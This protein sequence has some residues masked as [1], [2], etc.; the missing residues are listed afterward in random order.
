M[1]TKL[2]HLIFPCLEL[3]L[4][5]NAAGKKHN[6]Q[7]IRVSCLPF[8]LSFFFVTSQPSK[9]LYDKKKQQQKKQGGISVSFLDSNVQKNPKTNNS[10]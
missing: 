5:F 1:Q 10:Q 3:S 6:S 9:K 4:L 2:L 8:D 7:S